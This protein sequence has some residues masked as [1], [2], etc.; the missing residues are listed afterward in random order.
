MTTVATAA[1][2]SSGAAG[3]SASMFT[4]VRPDAGTVTVRVTSTPDWVRNRS[5]AVA[6][7]W[8][9]LASRMNVSKKGPVAPSARSHCVAGALTPAESCPALNSTSGGVPKYIARSATAGSAKVTT[10]PNARPTSAAS[11]PASIVVRERGAS[12]TTRCCAAAPSISQSMVAVL[13]ALP[14]LASSR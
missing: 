13:A 7:A 10:M 4:V 5:V 11:A 9:G 12:D 2:A 1:L 8:F 14:G 6:A 3:V